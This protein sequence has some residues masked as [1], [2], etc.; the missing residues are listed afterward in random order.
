[1]SPRRRLRSLL[2]ATRSCFEW[3]LAHYVRAV[4]REDGVEV[5]VFLYGAFSARAQAGEAL[6]RAVADTR[7]DVVLGLK[8][9]TIPASA[10][11]RVRAAGVP[12]ALWNPDC[13][14]DAV[15][16]WIRPLLAQT[17]VFFTTAEGMVDAYRAVC[18]APVHWLVEGAHLPSFP[19]VGEPPKRYRSQVAF[20]GN[21]F[22]PPVDDESMAL[23]RLRLLS[24]V[25][26]RFDL[27]VWGPQSPRFDTH[28][29]ALPFRTVRWPAY[30]EECVKICRAAD[31]VLG[32]NTVDTVRRYFSNRTYLTLASG[33]FH[34]TSYVPGL[35]TLFEDGRHL[36]WYRS[37]EECMEKIEHYLARPD[38]RARIAQAGRHWVR[39]RF[40]L[41]EQVR[42][43]REH[44]ERIDGPRDR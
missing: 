25:G 22:Q 31:I 34:L 10:L 33:G 9:E 37:E 23:R 42:R 38:E 17:D 19:D 5:D 32:I 27:T 41:A 24:A 16:D 15:P 3:D 39:A 18:A 21:V 26:E 35:E 12:I 2:I 29:G 28:P 13:F 6:V 1:M 11:A 8:L 7:P 36:A 14:T 44:L 40:D 30:N 43:L 4:L 20:L